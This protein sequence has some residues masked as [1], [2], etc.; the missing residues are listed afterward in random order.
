MSRY[1][2]GRLP[3]ALAAL[4]L[5]C[6]GPGN[7]GTTGR[8]SNRVALAPGAAVGKL[9]SVRSGAGATYFE[10]DAIGRS[11]RTQYVRDHQ[12]YA[13]GQSYGYPQDPTGAPGSVVVA[14]T[15]PSASDFTRPGETVRYRFDAG[16]RL[17]AISSTPEGGSAQDVVSDITFN[18]RGQRISV[19][20]G[21]GV[22]TAYSYNDGGDLRLHESTTR[23]GGVTLQDF[24]YGYDESDNVTSIDDAVHAA[25]S[26]TNG[27]DSLDQLVRWNAAPYDYDASGNLTLLEGVAQGYGGSGRGPHAL[28]TAGGVSY[29]YD[30]D[31]NLTSASEGLTLTWDAQNRPVQATKGGASIARVYLD[32]ALISRN[33]V[34][35]AS[36]T[37]V[38]YL[39]SLRVE[40]GRLRTYYGD[41]AERAP[42]GTLTWHGRDH[43]ASTT[44]GTRVDGSVAYQIAYSPYGRERA[45]APF[46]P[47]AEG[48]GPAYTFTDKEADAVGFLDYGARLYNPNTGRWASPDTLRNDGPNGYAYVK[49]NPL[50]SI[51]PTGHASD[52]PPVYKFSIEHIE[53]TSLLDRI[54]AITPEENAQIKLDIY[55]Q[56]NPCWA[57]PRRRPPPQPR[58]QHVPGFFERLGRLS[59][60]MG[61]NADLLD[62]TP[63]ERILEAESGVVGALA[64]T[65]A[66]PRLTPTVTRNSSNQLTFSEGFRYPGE[67]GQRSVVYIEPAGSRSKDDAAA[68]R[69][70]GFEKQP[71]GFTW[72]HVDYDPVSG[73]FRMELV[74]TVVHQLEPHRGGVSDLK[75]ETGKPYR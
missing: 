73:V 22:V 8:A 24:V 48:S 11:V 32:D 27:Y 72:H 45:D 61:G 14:S 1:P 29:G 56:T 68:N 20:Y 4:A 37:L 63:Q 21:N 44:L 23:L 6:A 55:C 18:A 64:G 36:Q 54:K 58:Q 42:D 26:S 16:D 28:A 15:F 9:T 34:S 50:R 66:A 75:R 7:D 49:N 10:Y 71:T 3:A 47:V 52:D 69:A 38:H 43:L 39:P 65:V 59:L 40:N 30:L 33:E 2:S 74:P 70:G 60:I 25:L 46:T 19:R 17:V 53:Y 13:L 67:P 51:D 41:F 35:A 5:T 62:L 31:G 57:A 12:I